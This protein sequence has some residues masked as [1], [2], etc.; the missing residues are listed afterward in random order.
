M[1]IGVVFPQTEFGTDRQSIRDFTQAAEELGYS[2]ILAFDHV[3]GAEHSGRE[4]PLF[5]R[6]DEN[7]TFH[8]PL[9]LFSYMCALTE[10]IGFVTGV[11]IL[12][13]RQTVLVAKQVA[14]LAVLSG[15][16]FRLGV[17]V[18][19]NYLEY[20]ALGM[21]FGDRGR[22]QEEQIQLLRALW[23]E[24][25]L[26][27]HTTDHDLDRGG[28]L[29]RPADPVPIW[30]GGFAEVAERRAA[31]VADGFLF[32]RLLEQTADGPRSEPNE[33]LLRRAIR[34]RYELA[35][36]GRSDNAFG[37]EGRLNYVDGPAGWGKDFKAFEA[38]RFSHV[39]I[40][41]M[42]AGLNSPRFHIE[43]IEHFATE[44]GL[45]RR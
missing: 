28:I 31:R 6:Y 25:V 2:H 44:M 20:Q 17:G 5:G 14:E 11:M 39:A 42:D 9:T 4:Q 23:T 34:I 41:T 30:L 45:A 26:D 35:V 18:G 1:R 40:N 32:T 36:A 29:P 12:P 33:N 10:Q 27:Y 24:P 37:L 13:Q 8:E 22:R 43:A 3:F 19:W 7:T 16:R 38:A 21:R 15:N